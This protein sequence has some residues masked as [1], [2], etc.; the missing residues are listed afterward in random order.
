[1][2]LMRLTIQL[3]QLMGF[4]LYMVKFDGRDTEI[5][6]LANTNLLR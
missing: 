3:D 5:L 6:E 1:M 2:T 4:S